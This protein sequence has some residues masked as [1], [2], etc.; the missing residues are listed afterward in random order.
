MAKSTGT[1]NH[2]S[3]GEAAPLGSPGAWG[4]LLAGW[5]ERRARKK[6]ARSGATN[7][8]PISARTKLL[9][10]NG[11]VTSPAIFC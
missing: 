11:A 8:M 10:Q 7:T 6:R 4:N 2:T 1:I 3:F 5:L 9:R